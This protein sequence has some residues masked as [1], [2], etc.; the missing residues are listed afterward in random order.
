M[1]H[2]STVLKEIDRDNVKTRD[3]ALKDYI[4]VQIPQFVRQTVEKLEK[5]KEADRIAE[6][7]KKLN[8]MP[9]SLYK[10]TKNNRKLH[11]AL[12]GLSSITFHLFIV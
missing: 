12:K 6:F 2:T 3:A 8:E 1:S 9:Y 7:K 11:K 5:E 10:D 4:S